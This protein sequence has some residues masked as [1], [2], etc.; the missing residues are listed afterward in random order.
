MDNPLC[1][2]AWTALAHSSWREAGNKSS[3][4]HGC[5]F[6]CLTVR[7]VHIENL[8]TLCADSFINAVMRFSARR[9]FPAKI[10]SDNGTNFVAWER[11]IREVIQNRN[12]DNGVRGHLLQKEIQVDFIWAAYGRG[13]VGQ[14]EWCW[15]PFSK[16]NSK[17]RASVHPVLWSWG[18]NQW[19]AAYHSIW[20]PKWW[21][22]PYSQS[23]ATAYCPQS[24]QSRNIYGKRKRHV[25]YLANQFWK[26]W[27]SEYLPTL[28]FRQKWV[29]PK[30]NK[31]CGDIAL[32]TTLPGSAGL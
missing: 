25:Q 18:D 1:K 5:L 29:Q 14:S 15:I 27:L 23:S 30:R 10:R 28:Q 3:G 8:Y 13:K 19:Q 26:R 20:W 16:T 17:Q 12:Q 31:E 7:A 6:T 24:F 4:R 9:G 22:P 11:E 21:V 2:W 32:T